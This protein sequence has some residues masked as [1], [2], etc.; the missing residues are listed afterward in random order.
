MRHDYDG[1]VEDRGLD[2]EELVPFLGGI[3]AE[4]LSLQ[5]KRLE[6]AAQR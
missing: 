3:D 2:H 1:L 6:D 4:Q 5:L